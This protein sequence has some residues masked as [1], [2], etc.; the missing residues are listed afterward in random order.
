MR[1]LLIVGVP[2]TVG[3]LALMVLMFVIMLNDIQ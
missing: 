1:L 2:T 3:W